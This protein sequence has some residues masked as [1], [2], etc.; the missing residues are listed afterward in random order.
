MARVFTCG[1]VAK[2][3]DAAAPAREDIVEI[4]PAAVWHE[5]E[6]A[7]SCLNDGR[8]TGRDCVA[9]TV[10]DRDQGVPRQPELT[11]GRPVDRVLRRDHEV[12][13]LELASRP[14]LE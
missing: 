5:H 6:Q 7:V 3:S 14:D 9:V 2:R 12:D 8:A 10:D 11:N 13:E 4:G 1:V